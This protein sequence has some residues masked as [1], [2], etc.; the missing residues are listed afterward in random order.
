MVA[1]LGVFFLRTFE[2]F[3]AFWG[4][5]NWFWSFFG[6][7]FIFE[8]FFMVFQSINQVVYRIFEAALRGMLVVF[9]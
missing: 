3:K 7:G 9:V 2:F 4:G 5:L 6:R 8:W 1:I